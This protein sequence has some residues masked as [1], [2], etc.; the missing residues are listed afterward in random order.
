MANFTLCPHIIGDVGDFTGDSFMRSPILPTRMLDFRG[1]ATNVQIKHLPSC[2][3]C[4]PAL[5]LATQFV[6]LLFTFFSFFW[7]TVRESLCPLWMY[8]RLELLIQL[9]P[10][11]YW[12]IW[13]HPNH[14]HSRYK[15]GLIQRQLCLST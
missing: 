14:A 11:S 3:C 9:W 6:C 10:M 2:W 13:E 1:R 5:F 12:E 7:A 4:E 8:T 15:L